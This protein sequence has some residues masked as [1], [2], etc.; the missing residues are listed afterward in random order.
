MPTLQQIADD[1]VKQYKQWVDGGRKKADRGAYYGAKTPG[2]T[3][4]AQN[5]PGT[6]L[7]KVTP[8]ASKNGFRLDNS[9]S[10][11]LSYRKGDFI[12]HCKTPAH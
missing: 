6:L 8:L 1:M 12:Y 4:G 2:S 3:S 11:D 10:S 9:R 7:P 5:I